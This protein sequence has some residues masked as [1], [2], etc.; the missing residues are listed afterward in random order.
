VLLRITGAVTCGRSDAAGVLALASAPSAEPDILRRVT[1]I[2][3]GH[4]H[5][6]LLGRFPSRS[7]RRQIAPL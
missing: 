4:P 5:N 7:A 2:V 6:D 1:G 3:Q